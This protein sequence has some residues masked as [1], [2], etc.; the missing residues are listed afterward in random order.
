MQKYVDESSLFGLELLECQWTCDFLQSP[1]RP[2]QYYSN[3]LSQKSLHQ[4]NGSLLEPRQPGHKG[5]IYLVPDLL[6][7][8]PSL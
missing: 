1:C 5:L 2:S 3:A 4:L 6:G 7:A 8:C